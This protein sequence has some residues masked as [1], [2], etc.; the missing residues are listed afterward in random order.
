MSLSLLDA[1]AESTLAQSPVPSLRTLR[2]TESATEV[3]ITG[4][5]STYYHKQLAQEAVRPLLG[6]RQLRNRVTV[7]N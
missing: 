3:V 6:G 7:T 5:V 4:S 1:S 2:V